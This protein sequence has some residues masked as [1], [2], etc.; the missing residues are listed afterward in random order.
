MRIRLPEEFFKKKKDFS[1]KPVVLGV[2]PEDIFIDNDEKKNFSEEFSAN[3][4]L[5]ELLGHRMNIYLLAGKSK[6]LATVDASFKQKTGVTPYRYGAKPYT[7]DKLHIALLIPPELLV[8][9][10]CVPLKLLIFA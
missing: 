7:T 6:L 9:D 2:R 10:S 1:G 8:P 3:L 4:D 5:S